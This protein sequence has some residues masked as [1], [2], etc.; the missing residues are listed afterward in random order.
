M[1]AEIDVAADELGEGCDDEDDVGS[2]VETMSIHP[3]EVGLEEGDQL[4]VDSD[5]GTE[6]DAWSSV[7]PLRV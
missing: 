5:G 2:V 4:D 3:S 6:S 7:T 1:A